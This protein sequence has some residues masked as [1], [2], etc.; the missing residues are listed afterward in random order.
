IFYSNISNAIESVILPAP[1]PAGTTQSRNVGHGIYSGAQASVNGMLTDGLQLG[2]NVSYIV[3]RMNIPAANVTPFQLTGV[4][5]WKA[6]FYA[7]WTVLPELTVTPT[8]DL[9]SNRWENNTAGT[10]YFRTGAFANL[11]VSADYRFTDW[12][13]LNLGVKNIADANYQLNG[14]F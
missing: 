14:G 4:P 5:T 8:L 6:F 12:L 9:A 2:A 7:N 10:V 1:A 11:S 13:D 3:R